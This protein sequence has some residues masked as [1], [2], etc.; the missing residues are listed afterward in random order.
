MNTVRSRSLALVAGLSML[1]VSGCDSPKEG[2]A[3]VKS[4]AAADNKDDAKPAKNAEPAKKP[5]PAAKAEPA[6]EP[7]PDVVACDQRDFIPE[8]DKKMA[9]AMGK[10]PKP[11]LVCMDYSGRT[12]GIG[13]PSCVQGTALETPCPDDDVV[14][15][16]TMS[17]GTVF[18]HY[19]GT[20]VSLDEKKCKTLE[21]TFAKK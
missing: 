8:G 20:T 18:K 21:G 15:T 13:K 1:V 10:E 2:A 4:A 17:N 19:K 5:E 3:E 6:P 16:C 7:E 14:A 11:K 12:G 9:A